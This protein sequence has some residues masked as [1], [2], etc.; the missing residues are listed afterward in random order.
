MTIPEKR[1]GR[2][3]IFD[4]QD[5]EATPKRPWSKRY[6]LLA[7][8][9]IAALLLSIV[10]ALPGP[11]HNEQPSAQNETADLS[12]ASAK[13][14]D[15]IV[16]DG[17][18]VVTPQLL[19]PV[20]PGDIDVTAPAAPGKPKAHVNRRLAHS[21]LATTNTRAIAPWFN[22]ISKRTTRFD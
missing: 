15:T 9:V 6:G 18:T 7:G 21:R 1:M 16:H 5:L 3:I 12:S 14:G 11:T 19:V 8:G 2:K 22:Q 10:F 13:P 17:V 20:L 4:Y